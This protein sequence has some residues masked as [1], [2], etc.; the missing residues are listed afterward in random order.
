MTAVILL[1][2]FLDRRIIGKYRR[3]RESLDAG[4][5]I[6]LLLQSDI[7]DT[8]GL[9]EDIRAVRYT[10]GDLCSMDYPA[11]DM[12]I[13]P[14]SVHFVM[15]R[16]RLDHPGY[17][18]YWSVE[19]DVE[20]DGDWRA[21][22]RECAAHDADLIACDIQDF[23]EN[24]CWYWWNALVLREAMVPLIKRTRSFNP[25]YRL[26][27]RALDLLHRRQG[28]GDGGHFEVLLPTLLKAYGMKL[29]DLHRRGRYALPGLSRDYYCKEAPQ[30]H[31]SMRHAPAIPTSCMD[32]TSGYLFHP[33]KSDK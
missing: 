31:G 19:Y 12:R 16:F 30:P 1:T 7:E 22:F 13:V 4:H 20:M 32:G 6:F 3:M 23:K 2:H 15:L 17:S 21:I 5:D 8:A 10:Y 28:E 9:P 25:I 27:S 33:V 24:P 18:H 11:I 26:S 29:G 14:G